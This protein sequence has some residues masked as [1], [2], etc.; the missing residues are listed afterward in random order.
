MTLPNTFCT[1]IMRDK[2]RMTGL[3]RMSIRSRRFSE[4]KLLIKTESAERNAPATAY[5]IFIET[6]EKPK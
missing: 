6:Q 5:T 3:K 2:D 4:Y 1:E